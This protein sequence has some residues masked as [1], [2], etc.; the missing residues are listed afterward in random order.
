MLN[1]LEDNPLRSGPPTGW[2]S[3]V[4]FH[5]ADDAGITV[6]GIMHVDRSSH[7]DAKLRLIIGEGLAAFGDVGDGLAIPVLHGTIR[8]LHNKRRT[9]RVLSDGT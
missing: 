6:L 5:P 1:T 4:H 3:I 2:G 8:F 9:R 7:L